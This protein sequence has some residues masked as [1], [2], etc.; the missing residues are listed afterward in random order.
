VHYLLTLLRRGPVHIREWKI[1]WYGG[2]GAYLLQ[3]AMLLVE[4]AKQVVLLSEVL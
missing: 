2:D 1:D 3:D 4:G